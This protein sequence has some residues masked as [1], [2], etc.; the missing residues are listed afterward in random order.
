MVNSTQTRVVI[1]IAAIIWFVVAF[2]SGDHNGQWT[3]LR[4]F[5]TAGSVVTL[6]FLAYDRWIW[7]LPLVRMFTRKPNLN[8][9]WRGE[10]HSDFERDSKKIDP[11][12]AAIR[13]KQ[14]NSQVW[15]TQFTGESSSITE[16]S[17]LVKEVDDRW[18]LTF[19]YT[20]RP[21]AQVRSQ[22]DQHQGLCEL[23][24]AG[25]DDSL[26][27]SY[28]TSRK[29]TGEV[30]FSEWSKARYGD[31]ASAIASSNFSKPNPFVIRHVK[32]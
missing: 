11:I 8:G 16:M 20:N 7:A 21:R 28:F 6:L 14:T 9:T 18:R 15:V 17:E 30:E 5:S 1:G 24:L 31:A 4:T 26:S 13:I 32:S 29:T 10:L 12:P 27:G 22:S 3:A 25:L 23:Y 19:V 2:I